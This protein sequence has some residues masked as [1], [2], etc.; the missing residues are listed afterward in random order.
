MRAEFQV[1][2]SDAALL[3]NARRIAHEFAQQYIRDDI[4]G[5]VFLGAIARGYF[6]HAADIDIALFTTPTAELALPGLFL[7]VEEVMVH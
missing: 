3:T 4:V 2:S 5:I 7:T 6:D 1:Q